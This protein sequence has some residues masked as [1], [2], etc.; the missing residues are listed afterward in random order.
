MFESLERLEQIVIADYIYHSSHPSTEIDF[1]EFGNG[2]AKTQFT[3]LKDLFERIYSKDQPYELANKLFMIRQTKGARENLFKMAQRSSGR[4]DSEI[5]IFGIAIF[6]SI[7]SGDRD[8]FES[9]FG[10]RSN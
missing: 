5:N 6:G 10:N 1:F 4:R 9:L 2:G 8:R 3:M 7:A